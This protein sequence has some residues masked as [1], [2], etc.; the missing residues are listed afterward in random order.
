M[1]GVVASPSQYSAVEEFFELFKT[2]WEFCKTDRNYEV[3]ICADDGTAPHSSANLT[4]VY[5]GRKLPIDA[6]G[7][8]EITSSRR[9][10]RVLSGDGMRIPIYGDS[11]TFANDG[12]CILRDEE[13]RHP[14]TYTACAAGGGTVIRIGY[15]L[16]DEVNV[17]LIEGQPCENASIPALE[18]H[19][20]V[21]RTLIVSSGIPL[22]EI[23][24]VP[25]GYRFIACLTHDVD[26]PAIRRHMFDRT[27]FGFLYR[28]V[29]T[30]LFGV[31]RGR[32]SARMLFTNWVAV[33]KLPFVYL[34]IA[35]DFWNQLDT[36]TRLDGGGRSSFFVIPF[37]GR[38]GSKEGKLAPSHRASGYSAADVAAVTQQLQSEGHEIGLHGI[39]A[40]HDKS[41]GREELDEI[42]RI[43][44]EREI[45]TRMHW[46]YFDNRSP[47]V[48][49]DL[50]VDY[51]STV[52][53][54]EAVGYRAGTAQVYK[55][56]NVTRLLEL[57]LHVMDTALFL[58]GRQHLSPT[59]A[60][61]LVEAIIDHATEFGGVVTVNWH[62]RSIAP[63]RLW[64]DFYAQ[65]LDECKRKGA[66]FASA[67]DTVRWFR[68]RR[69]AKFDD[70]DLKAGKLKHPETAERL[71]GMFLRVHNAG[72]LPLHNDDMSRGSSVESAQT[73]AVDTT[74]HRG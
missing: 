50:G 48:L 64:L 54:N 20:S 44:G 5:C 26:H 51:D 45:G 60:S 70:L 65:L 41:K 63:E 66:W 28:A 10:R 22:K 71:P 69:A 31:L 8:V 6:F 49:E 42:R 67:G 23:P 36:Y 56:L 57:P 72:F 59:E 18:F 13:S 43:T 33:L 1:I 73:E 17:L 37:K 55:P 46:L 61:K 62:D 4:V 34:G 40:W 39:D 19:I 11:V 52:G 3:L 21:L 74:L 9:G 47:A 27:M 58:S 14:A 29:I 30:S 12:A 24:P 35:K 38:P 53:Y 15:D 16:F 68:R 7:N 32:A 25:S 2:P